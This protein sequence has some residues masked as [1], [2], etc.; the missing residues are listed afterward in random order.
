MIPDFLKRAGD[1]TPGVYEYAFDGA[2]GRMT[3]DLSW[4]TMKRRGE[5]GGEGSE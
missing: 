5:G 3:M 4:V 2:I 1:G